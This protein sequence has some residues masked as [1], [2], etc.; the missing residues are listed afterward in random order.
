MNQLSGAPVVMHKKGRSTDAAVLEEITRKPGVTIAEIAENLE[1]TNGKIDG[2]VNRLV[3]EGKA[4]VKHNLKRGML[5][6]TVYPADFDKK[7]DNIVQIPMELVNCDLWSEKAFV[8]ALS[9]STIGIAPHEVEEW[10]VK[11][12]SAEYVSV[13][14]RPEAVILILPERLAGFYQLDNS[15]ISLSAVGDLVFVTVETVL[16]VNFIPQSVEKSKYALVQ[17]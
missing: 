10:G 17:H 1:W 7:Q 13:E 3:A 15:E 16:P 12:F 14:K 8:Y 2:S 9:R 6:K 5:V 11:A 4:S